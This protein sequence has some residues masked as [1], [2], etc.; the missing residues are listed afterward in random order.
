MKIYFAIV[1]TFALPYYSICCTTSVYNAKSYRSQRQKF[2]NVILY[3]HRCAGQNALFMIQL[4][5]LQLLGS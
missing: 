3:H 2:D 1:P 5:T 4:V